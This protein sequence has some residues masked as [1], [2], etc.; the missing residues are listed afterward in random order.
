MSPYGSWR[1]LIRFTPNQDISGATVISAKLYLYCYNVFGS[2]T[3]SVYRMLQ[4][5]IESQVT[6]NKWDNSN[7]WHEA[8]AEDEN[9]S[10]VDDDV[11]YDR[12]ATVLDSEGIS[13]D[14]WY[15]WDITALV[16]DWVDGDIKEYGVYI[17]SNQDS[18][19]NQVSFRSSESDEDGYLPYLE[20]TYTP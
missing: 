8:G 19:P 5:W 9:D 13:I 11:N 20:I 15:N 14:S 7:S 6:W 4:N 10:G 3:V 16:Q 12:H 2:H 18:S 17:K 1:T